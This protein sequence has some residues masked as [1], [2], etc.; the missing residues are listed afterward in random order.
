MRFISVLLWIFAFILA[1]CS[2]IADSKKNDSGELL[3]DK[4]IL[5][6]CHGYSSEMLAIDPYSYEDFNL[7]SVLST[8]M[9]YTF[10]FYEWEGYTRLTMWATPASPIVLKDK[11]FAY[12]YRNGNTLFFCQI[13]E[14]VSEKAKKEIIEGIV[15]R[16]V[17]ELNILQKNGEP[18][19]IDY[20]YE[21]E[22]WNKIEQGIDVGKWILAT[23]KT[24]KS[25]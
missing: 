11:L 13:N 7:F 24:N 10:V 6:Y 25:M 1:G 20:I 2:I 9:N 22:K 23:E 8:Q 14:D 21:K 3:V 12:A 15:L 18:F 19:S 16:S 5:D 4:L 17:K